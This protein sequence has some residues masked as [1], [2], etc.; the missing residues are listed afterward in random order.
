MNTL[1]VQKRDMETKPKALR[2]EGF[3]VG[4]L[5]GKSID[6]SIPL[7]IEK[8][9]A[10]RIRKECLKGSQLLLDLD[11]KQYDVLLKEVQYDFLSKQILEME[12]QALVQGEKVHSVAEIVCHNKD[13]VV[14]GILEQLLREVSYKATPENLVNQIDI[15]CSTLKLGDSLTVADLDIA[16]NGKVDIMTPLDAAVV[17]VIAPKGSAEDEPAAEEE[18][19]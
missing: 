12:F 13:K 2:R 8:K 10:E 3:T 11:G 15:D 18:A 14:G 7:Q 16:K 17:A 19:N 1:K 9:E 6:G 5:F 4:N